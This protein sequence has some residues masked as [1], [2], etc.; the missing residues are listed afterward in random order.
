MIKND[1][2]VSKS[3]NELSKDIKAILGDNE[4]F[5]IWQNVNG[6]KQV[7]PGVINSQ[8]LTN[9][10]LT[11]EFEIIDG[12]KIR[13]K[14]KVFMFC[15]NCSMLLKGKVKQLS[16]SKLKVLIDHKF[17]LKEKRMAARM[18][19]SSS[20]V[21]AMI[22]RKIE[23][24]NTVKTEDVRLKNISG[25]GC[26]FYITSNRAVFFQPGSEIIIK[27]LGNV[28]LKQALTGEITHIT[29]VDV[30]FDSNKLMLVGIHFQNEC[31]NI[32]EIVQEVELSLLESKST[33][34]KDKLA[35]KYIG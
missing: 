3:I 21:H 19:L 24:K 20:E 8:F 33:S 23:L 25:Y 18:E 28:P 9:T 27:S 26:G 1:L 14:T 11:I 13:P 4:G 12:E 34:A 17:Y 22:D 29:P 16:K 32:E 10:E 35:G 7:I 6:E 5:T 2:R 30:N 15:E 31:Q